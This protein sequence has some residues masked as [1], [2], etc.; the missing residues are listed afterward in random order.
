VPNQIA[1]STADMSQIRLENAG[2]V[3]PFS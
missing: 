3:S 2:R 1:K